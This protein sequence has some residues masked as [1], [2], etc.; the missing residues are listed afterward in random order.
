MLP[1]AYLSTL[2]LVVFVF[3]WQVDVERLVCARRQA[4]SGYFIH[5]CCVGTVSFFKEN[6]SIN[7]DDDDDS[8]VSIVKVIQTQRAW[9]SLDQDGELNTGID[10]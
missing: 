8:V 1:A 7:V 9:E 10:L 5:H 6:V 3:F 4:P 2:P